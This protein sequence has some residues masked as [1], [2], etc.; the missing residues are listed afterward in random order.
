VTTLPEAV[1][2]LRAW[3]EERDW[4]GYDP[5]DALNSP[6]APLL[7][8]GTR[9]GRRLLTQAVKRS[10]LNLRP[11][12]GIRPAWNAKALGLI[13]S[14]YVRLAAAGDE[15]AR[16]QARRWLGWLEQNNCGGE[17]G[18][19]W[20]YN[21]PVQTRFFRYERGAP[22]AIAT[23]FVA[24]AFLDAAELL[25]EPRWKK[26]ANA[27]ARFLLARMLVDGERTYFRY[28]SQEDELVHNANLLACSVLARA[29]IDEPTRSAVATSLVAQR[30]DGSWPYSES[31][32]GAWVDN[33]HTAYNLES[34]THCVGLE[35]AVEGA[36]HSGAEFWRRALFLDD[37]T[38]KYAP[39]SLYPIDAHCYASAIDA[40]LALGKPAEA[41]RL[42]GLLVERMLDPSGYVWSQR[43]RYGTNRVP[44]VRWSTAPSFKALTGLLLGSQ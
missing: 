41:E 27:A 40:W 28:L 38:P 14:A 39:E 23:S 25:G 12:L 42:A 6:A 26:P 2:R 20:G 1:D 29:G 34:L 22:N 17:A 36:I 3:G 7:T 5:Y 33:F 37:G 24:H 16:L 9:L 31:P 15:S 18:L 30:P 19:A 13:A 8:I 21:F 10:P 32:Q 35:A 43:H 11:A 4:R 44:L